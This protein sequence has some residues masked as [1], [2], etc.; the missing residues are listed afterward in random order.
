WMNSP[1][2]G[3]IQPHYSPV[4]IAPLSINLSHADCRPERSFFYDFWYVD[5]FKKQR[6]RVGKFRAVHVRFV[7][8]RLVGTRARPAVARSST[9]TRMPRAPNT[10]PRG[11]VS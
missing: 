9:I 10:P 8:K 3:R 6:W 4:M 11:Q 1:S 7:P 2:S 5:L